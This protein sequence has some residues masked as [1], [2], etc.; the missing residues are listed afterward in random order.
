MRTVRTR[1][2]MRTIKDVDEF[3]HA[4]SWQG[5]RLGLERMEELMALLGHPEKNMRFIHVTGTNGKGSVAVMLASIL[6]QAGY[7][8]GLY[9]SPHLLR[10]NERMKIDGVDISDKDLMSVAEE[11][12]PAVD[13][14]AD[15]PTEFERITAMALLYFQM[16]DCDVVVLEVG[17]GGRLDATNIIP[18]PDAAVITNIALEHTSVLGNTL[19]K[20]AGEKSGII[21]KGSSVILYSQN[22]LVETVVQAVCHRHSTTLTI[23]EPELGKTLSRTLEG[24][25]LSYR[26]REELFVHLP[27][28]YQK[29]NVFTA[30]DTVDALIREKGYEISDNAI[31]KGLSLV[32]WPCR[33]EVLRRNPLMIVDGAHNPDGVEALTSCLREYFPRKKL[34]FVMGVMADKNYDEMLRMV[35]PMA[36]RFITVRPDCERAL[37]SAQLANHIQ[38]EFFVPAQDGGSVPRGIAHAMSLCNKEDVI[39]IFGSLYQAGAARSFILETTR[40]ENKE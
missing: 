31:R 21:K 5:S 29:G 35:V 37:S 8:T 24:Q 11:V 20:I 22:L 16:Q 30:L 34:T 19:E 18:A 32:Q 13:W 3:L 28:A 15:S 38:K 33:L 27:G 26:S 9:T 36:E 25:T 4:T 14:M 40:R 12:R 17:M 6:T 23:T 39:C 1:R 10:V 7:K 2:S